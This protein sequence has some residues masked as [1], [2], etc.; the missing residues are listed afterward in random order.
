MKRAYLTLKI[1]FGDGEPKKWLNME[2]PTKDNFHL[3]F[4]D[5]VTRL[6]REMKRVS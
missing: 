4:W 5:E 6:Y 2:V 1:D 3:H